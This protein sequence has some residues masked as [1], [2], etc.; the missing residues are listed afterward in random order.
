V[1]AIEATDTK[2]WRWISGIFELR[3]AADAF[4]AS[5]PAATRSMQKVVGIP[6]AGYPFF[7]IEDGGFE[8]GDLIF[9]RTRLRGLRAAGDE[10]HN[11]MN[12]YSASEDFAPTPPGID[13]MG[14]LLHWH[15]TDSTLQPP[16]FGA[17][18]EDLVRA[19]AT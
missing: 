11:D 15:V 6:V 3:A 14:A 10:D 18:D 5:M 9:L 2:G 1:F 12:V 8:Y 7:I 16:Q 17:L 4:V 13:A 19:G